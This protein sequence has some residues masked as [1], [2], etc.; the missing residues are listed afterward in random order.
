[1]YTHRMPAIGFVADTVSKGYNWM[2]QGTLKSESSGPPAVLVAKPIMEEA[3]ST[4]LS[5]ALAG[6]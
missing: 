6:S 3:E 2:Q 4:K 1:M 5:I